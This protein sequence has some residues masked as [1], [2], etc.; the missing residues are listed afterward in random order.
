MKNLIIFSVEN[1]GEYLDIDGVFKESCKFGT[2]EV[3][4]DFIWIEPSGEN[5]I[6]ANYSIYIM[7][8]KCE[9][10]EAD[11]MPTFIANIK[12]SERVFC[13]FHKGT[14]DNGREN[15]EII[16]SNYNLLQEQLKG[17]FL[18]KIAIKTNP[19]IK[20]YLEEFERILDNE[21]DEK[22]TKF[23]KHCEK[24]IEKLLEEKTNNLKMDIL[25]FFFGVQSDEELALTVNQC[26]SELIEKPKFLGDKEK[27][28]IKSIVKEAMSL[29]DK[30]LKEK[31]EYLRAQF[32]L[33]T[34]RE[35]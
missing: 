1:T 26:N 27:N 31:I 4:C 32:F 28:N 34:L 14:G 30:S 19:R 21:S 15:A 33:N 24:I 17:I 20:N 16:K 29:K 18:D 23:E 7:H 2:D 9:I 10:V 5:N 6:N 8:D 25:H 3:C 22:L 13:V 35:V 12:N 11:E